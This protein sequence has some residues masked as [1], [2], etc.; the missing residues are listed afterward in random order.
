MVTEVA[1]LKID[2]SEADA[3]EGMYGEVVPVL[4]RQ[5]GYRSDRLMRAIERPEEYILA[6]EWDSVD[7]HQAF[8]DSDEYSLMSNPFGEFVL[9]SGFAHYDTVRGS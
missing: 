5:P 6:V 9:D 7:A 3:F 1:V 2:P 4:R 8:I